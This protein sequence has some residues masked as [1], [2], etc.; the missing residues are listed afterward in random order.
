MDFKQLRSFVT[1]VECGSFTGAASLLGVSQPTVSTH[2]RMLEEELG[3]PLV[4]R[5]AKRVELTPKGE[6][7]YDQAVDML[8]MYDHIIGAAR[9]RDSKTIYL[10]AS[11]IPSAYILPTVLSEFSQEYPDVKFVIYQDD[12]QG[13]LSSLKEGLFDLGVIGMS[14]EDPTIESVPICKDRLVLVTAATKQLVAESKRPSRTTIAYI[15][16]EN[17]IIERREGSASRGVMDQIFVE[18]GIAS[19][20]LNI[21]ARINDQEAIKNL[22]ETG[23]GVSVMSYRAVKDRVKEGRLVAFDFN[24]P[25]A[26][27]NL[28][29]IH[30][31]SSQM[32]EKT[33]QFLTF[34][35]LRCATEQ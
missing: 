35:R 19:E 10:G 11:S 23:L 26:T 2:V 18:E 27:R 4:L 33:Q 15:L 9:E 24:C 3:V 17:P 12:S 21:V 32:D 16:T 29:A 13:V 25:S 6:R 34:L 14:P 5:T 30:R 8:T 7:I 22:V 28:Y 20:S 31:S 1:V